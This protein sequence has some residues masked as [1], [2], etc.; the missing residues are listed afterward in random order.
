MAFFGKR[1]FAKLNAVA[2]KPYDRQ[3]E[4]ILPLREPT[5]WLRREAVADSLSWLGGLPSLPSGTAW[6]RH[7]LSGQPLHFLAQV[8]L[9]TLP[10]TPLQPGGAA[11]PREG[12]LLF[13]ADIE[14]EM[15][16]GFTGRGTHHDNT[17]VL[18]VASSNEEAQPPADLPEV[19]HAIGELKGYYPSG[20][21]VFPRAFIKPYRIDSYP[22]QNIYF[23]N[24]QEK[25]TDDLVIASIEA[26]TGES[27][28]RVQSFSV[29]NLPAVISEAAMLNG[30]VRRKIS[31]V[32][33]QML[34]GAHAVQNTASEMA[35]KGYVSL[36][37]LDSDY[38]VSDKFIFCD[39]G[40]VQFWIKPEDLAAQRFDKAFATTEGG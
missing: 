13:F 9:S 12:L 28:P 35:G 21:S 34:G 15:L 37:Q 36:F 31:I 1:L 23:Q 22:G 8:D 2:A 25:L 27:V 10:A 20:F 32:R 7:G 5:I 30:S 19:N 6:P 39:C 16:W 40:M 4:P 3:A 17:R 38:G 24:D 14:E 33:H 26:A 11:L 18:H 29:P